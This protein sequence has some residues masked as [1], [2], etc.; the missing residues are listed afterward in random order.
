MEF[1]VVADGYCKAAD[2]VNDKHTDFKA[3]IRHFLTEGQCS[4]V[5]SIRHHIAHH[6]NLMMAMPFYCS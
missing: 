3:V 1:L 4:E 6:P 2:F 5:H